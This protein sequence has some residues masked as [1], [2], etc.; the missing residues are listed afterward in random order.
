MVKAIRVIYKMKLDR[1]NYTTDILNYI[2]F[3]L[4]DIKLPTL[5]GDPFEKK[6]PNNCLN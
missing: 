5:Y 1:A 4:F 6:W 3:G 2:Y